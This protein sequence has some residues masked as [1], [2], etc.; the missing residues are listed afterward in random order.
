MNKMEYLRRGLCFHREKNERKQK[1]DLGRKQK[2]A[3]F[4]AQAKLMCLVI[5]HGVGA[6]CKVYNWN[7]G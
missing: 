6:F 3:I 1:C 7:G 5:L 4:I 2:V